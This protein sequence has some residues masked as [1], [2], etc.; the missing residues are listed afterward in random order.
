MRR[1]A[2]GGC[3]CIVC[4]IFIDGKPAGAVERSGRCAQQRVEE[5]VAMMAAV[6]V[7]IRR[8]RKKEEELAKEAEEKEEAKLND[9]T[10][11]NDEGL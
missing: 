5:P 1:G 10:E 6:L 11:L 8:R 3:K 7:A 4:W 2:L 9:E